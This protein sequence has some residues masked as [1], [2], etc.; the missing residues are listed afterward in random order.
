MVG[1]DAFSALHA[2]VIRAVGVHR[3]AEHSLAGLLAEMEAGRLYRSAGF[4]TLAEYAQRALKIEARK[5]RALA[6][7]GRRLV[8]FPVLD[9]A[10][11][12]GRVSWT[13]AR[14]LLR[15]VVPDTEGDWVRRAEELNSRDLE[16]EVG[17][18]VPGDRPPK[19]GD[20][21]KRP[22]RTR[23]VFTLDTVEA[24]VVREAMGWFKS[25]LGPDGNDMEKGALLAAMLKSML[26][27]APPAEA[28]NSEP[29]RVVLE[30]CPSCRKTEGLDAQVRDTLADEA[31]CDAEVVDMRPG[32]DQGR[33]SKTIPPKVR[34]I[35]L[36]RD[37]YRCAV[38]GCRCTLWLHVHHVTFWADGGR[39]PVNNLLTLCSQHH[40]LVHEGLLAI[41]LDGDRFRIEHADGREGSV[42]AS[43]QPL[44]GASWPTW[45]DS[46]RMGQRAGPAA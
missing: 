20:E 2:S 31:C 15:V 10:M 45:A 11:E 6:M 29:Y 3:R 46:E 16:H 7:L 24:D 30:T 9:Q 36:W 12:L 18:A 33:A 39:H 35:V 34:R 28:P 19:P 5:A 13:K 44:A 23:L 22:E 32:P 40:R 17:R 42:P 37:R 21:P 43:P 8:E 25:Q 26:V 4:A 38:P 27:T 1:S 14:E 41:W